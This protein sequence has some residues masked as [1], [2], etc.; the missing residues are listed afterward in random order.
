ML[1]FV[2]LTL[3]QIEIAQ[4]QQRYKRVAALVILEKANGNT[5]SIKVDCVNFTQAKLKDKLYMYNYIPL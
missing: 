2:P 5:S 3:W 4:Q 1:F